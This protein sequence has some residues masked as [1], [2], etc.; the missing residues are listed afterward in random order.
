MKKLSILAL[1][2]VGLL[3][4]A[5]SSDKD[6]AETQNGNLT[7]QDGD[8][9][10]SLSINLPTT[11]QASTRNETQT[12]D[13]NYEDGTFELNDGLTSEYEVKNALLV[14]F[15][16]A[17][18]GGENAAKFV[19]AYSIDPSWFTSSDKQVTKYS[20]KIV[21]KVGG[22]VAV[23]D[24][25][26]VIL[27]R[28]SL[29]EFTPSTSTFA[30]GGTTMTTSK[31]FEDF[32]N[33]IFTATGLGA[34]VMT[35][36]GFYMTNAP[37]TDKA[38]STTESIEG[39]TVRTL[40]PINSVYQTEAEALASTDPALVYV[41]RGMAKVTLQAFSS[42][43]KLGSDDTKSI[44][45]V[46]WTL[47]HT[48]K[49]SYAVRSTVG[50]SD[51]LSLASQQNGKYRYAGMT[52]ITE[53]T[54]TTYMY[55]TY[56]AIDPNYSRDVETTG[57][58]DLNYADD[59]DYTS[60]IGDENPQYCFENTFDVEHQTVMNTTL[61]RLKV[62]VG[63]GADLY[64]VQGNRGEILLND[65]VV[66]KAKN[67]AVNYIQDLKTAGTIN[68]TGD[69]SGD[70]FDVTVPNTAGTVTITVARSADY[71][72]HI[73][74][75]EPTDAQIQAAVNAALADVICYKDGMSYYTIRIK[76]FGDQLTPWHTGDAR[77]DPAPVVGNIYPGWRNDQNAS[78]A[79]N[80]RCDANYLGRYGVL[81]NNWYDI[82]VSSIKYLGEATP[83]NYKNDPTTDDELDGYI[84]AK[85]HILSWAKRTQN[86][87]L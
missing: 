3:V 16:P 21:Q 5:C 65:A 23:G 53:S 24:L 60:E 46:E 48:N 27:N 81:R 87:D 50:H 58:T 67:A 57:T 9:F 68:Y 15:R 34:E 86:W 73:T 10:I 17:S 20:S 82:R 2:A 69:L 79:D 75:E 85:I 7:Q 49:Y 43:L 40:V 39:A 32:R 66:T 22:D 25:L 13:N 4:G 74:G 62:Q 83:E 28:N 30:V 38:G 61:V 77:E 54:P 33:S 45:F 31:T 19:G 37:L 52:N 36:N 11:P 1:A 64:I 26:L 80:A 47:D 70:D 63:N 84:A 59:G 14:V 29:F 51:F 41:E 76:H 56:F 18:S 42:S 72:I 12:D 35:G 55:R 78:A 8:Q 71:D 44:T 6:V